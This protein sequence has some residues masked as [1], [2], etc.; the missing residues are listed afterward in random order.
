M[1]TYQ[2]HNTPP[3]EYE[4]VT[5]PPPIHAPGMSYSPKPDGETGIEGSVREAPPSRSTPDSAGYRRE[6]GELS[7]KELAKQQWEDMGCMCR[8][9]FKYTGLLLGGTV[10]GIWDCGS[11][12]CRVFF[13][14]TGLF[15]AGTVRGIWD[16]VSCICCGCFEC[17]GVLLGGI[18]GCIREY[19]RCVYGC[20]RTICTDGREPC[21]CLG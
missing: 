14:Y 9:F 10:C 18:A 21:P 5:K 7:R 15:L 17:M 11:W 12:W 20:C 6:N 1:S 19:M 4:L 2:I 13:K 16:R 3:T 8:V